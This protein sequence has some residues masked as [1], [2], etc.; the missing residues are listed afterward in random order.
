MKTILW[1]SRHEMTEDQICDLKRIM[2]DEIKLYCY[3]DTVTQIEK[4]L[5]LLDQADAIA[6]VLPLHLMAQLVAHANGKMVIQ[7]VAARVPSGIYRTLPDGRREQEFQ[8]I[9][10]FWQQIIK[11]E[12]EVKNL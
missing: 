4:I 1:I 3:R 2:H 6:A 11:L 12:Y 10:Q 5:P 9:H 7:S 8:F